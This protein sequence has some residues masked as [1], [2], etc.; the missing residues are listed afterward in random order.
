LARACGASGWV[1]AVLSAHAAMIANFGER[2]Q[3]EVWG[4]NP[5]AHASSSL[6]SIGRFKRVDGG[7]LVLERL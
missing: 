4:E 2:A 5:C 7:Y 6:S 1:Y 3:Q